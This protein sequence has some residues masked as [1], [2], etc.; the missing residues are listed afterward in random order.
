MVEISEVVVD[1]V[2][3]Q[4]VAQ[5]PPRADAIITLVAS[6]D[7]LPGAQTLLYSVQKNLRKNVPYPPEL[8]VLVTPEVSPETRRALWPALCT[9][10]TEVSVI[11]LPQGGINKSIGT[12][13]NSTP[14][15]NDCPGLTKLH[16]FSL[17][18]Y[19]T[20]VFLEP[21]CLVLDDLYPLIQKGKVYTE[22]EALV[23]AAPDLFPPD[24]FNSGVM[25]IR[26]NSETFDNMMAQ[27]S[28]LTNY[29]NNDTGFLNAYYSEW[30]TQMAPLARLPFTYNA[31]RALYD[32]TYPQGH[33][34]YWDIA[35]APDLKVLHYSGY[36]KPWEDSKPANGGSAKKAR[37]GDTLTDLWRQWHQK[38]HNYC[39]RY[40]KEREK[41][42]VWRA[43]AETRQKQLEQQ[44]QHLPKQQNPKQVHKLVSKRFKELR[45]EGH[46]TKDAMAMAR[47]EHGLSD[48]QLEPASVGA[49]VASMFGVMM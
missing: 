43:S 26:P 32:M 5:F 46:D 36:P 23:A 47:A 44:Q 1:P 21:D 33:F 34:N 3:V 19:D 6:D 29:A 22:S 41:E 14:F 25:V 30:F 20:I 4:V 31:Q 11:G 15:D 12:N 42:A 49:Q 28:L 45:Q 37:T 8:V 18:V 10:I 38:S 27:K 39:V 7:Y 13:Q 17:V 9:R 48:E 35:V 24:K 16:A 40:H 2:L